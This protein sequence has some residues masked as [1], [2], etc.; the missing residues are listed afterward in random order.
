MQSPFLCLL[1]CVLAGPASAKFLSSPTQLKSQYDFI[2][3]GG[4]HIFRYF[5]PS[6]NAALLK[7]STGGTAGNVV[8]A[9]LSEVSKYTVLL[10]EAG[11]K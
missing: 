2:V 5:F 3:V 4:E 1:L 6:P 7:M 8:A 10:I 11:G 9:R